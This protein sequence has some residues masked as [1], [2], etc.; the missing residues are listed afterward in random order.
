VNDWAGLFLGVIALAT[1]TTAVVQIMVIVAAG[2]L[3]RRIE[4]LTDR[5][6]Q[7]IKPMFGQLH[8]ISRDASRVSSL[9]TAQAERLDR[10]LGEMGGRLDDTLATLQTSATATA[11]EGAAVL[12][13]I[14]AALA[15]LKERR[16]GR[17]R[18]RAEE[19]DALFI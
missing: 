16:A 14:R 12:S 5:V 3:A 19:E 1:L 2:R 7:E 6:E 9:A 8:A 17:S 15:A 13:G 4:R 10:A 18:S 11:R